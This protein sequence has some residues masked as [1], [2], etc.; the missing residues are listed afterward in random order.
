MREILKKK[1]KK[2]VTEMEFG[3]S[4][5]QKGEVWWVDGT[6]PPAS[7]AERPLPRAGT[8]LGGS[9]SKLKQHFIPPEKK[10]GRE[11]Y[12]GAPPAYLRVPDGPQGGREN[13]GVEDSIQG[14]S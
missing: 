8:P 12:G 4:S 9:K 3:E 11:T 6:P 1:K 2:S 7:A 5:T 10:E 14:K 13:G